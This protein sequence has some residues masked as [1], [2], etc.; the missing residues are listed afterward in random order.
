[1]AYNKIHIITSNDRVG[2]C[3]LSASRTGSCRWTKNP[4]GFA[5]Q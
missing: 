2:Y 1:M 5:V 3:A 4:V